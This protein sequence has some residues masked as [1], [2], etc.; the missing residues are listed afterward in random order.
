MRGLGGERS[1]EGWKS[2]SLNLSGS[3]ALQPDS[4]PVELPGKTYQ[5]TNLYKHILKWILDH[6]TCRIW[7]HQVSTTKAS[8]V[9]LRVNNPPASA[10]D[11]GDLGLILGSGRFLGEGNGN[12]LQYSCLKNSTEEPGRPWGCK[13]S[14]MFEHALT[15]RT[16][17]RNNQS[18]LVANKVKV[19]L[20]RPWP[21]GTGF[22]PGKG[23]P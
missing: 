6:P 14:D 17:H 16:K 5:G 2:I 19:V 21:A 7:I 18:H 13:K 4:L 1:R 22:R 8:Q 15:H 11:A 3:L 20:K 23:G 9:A 12:P 10:G